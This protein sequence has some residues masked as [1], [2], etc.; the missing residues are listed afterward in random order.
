[1]ESRKHARCP[2]CGEQFEIGEIDGHPD[3]E[4]VGMLFQ[5]GVYPCQL[6]YF[7]HATKDCGTTFTVPAEDFL[8]FITEPVPEL[9]LAETERCGNECTHVESLQTCGLACRYAPFRRYL[10]A[11]RERRA[12]LAAAPPREPA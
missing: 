2:K 3:V 5:G 9:N 11:M 1:M 12:K 6:Y 10:I 8:P 4:P 7:N